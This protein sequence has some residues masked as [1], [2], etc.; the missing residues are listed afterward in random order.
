MKLFEGLFRG[1]PVGSFLFW[2]VDPDTAKNYV[3]YSFSPTTTS[4]T[5]PALSARRALRCPRLSL[6]APARRP[7][8]MDSS[9]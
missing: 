1:Y 6:Q 3:S 4:A 5:S 9:A 7:S 8:S 2:K